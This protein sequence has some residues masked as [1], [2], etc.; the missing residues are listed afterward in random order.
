M[1]HREVELKITEQGPVIV[2]NACLRKESADIVCID[3]DLRSKYAELI[4]TF[5]ASTGAIG[6]L[7]AADERTRHVDETKP[8]DGFTTVEFPEF[9]G[10]DG[11]RVY[12][13]YG[14]ARYSMGVV[15]IREVQA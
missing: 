13:S 15:L 2:N 8:R 6:I 5:S 4:G 12:A 7:L 10:D 1:T 3:I 9:T 14:P 11:W